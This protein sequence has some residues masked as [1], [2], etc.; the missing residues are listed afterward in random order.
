M[1]IEEI[2]PE[3]LEQLAPDQISE[4][5]EPT[6]E[7]KQKNRLSIIEK[8]RNFQE[9][10]ESLDEP[11]QDE[12]EALLADIRAHGHYVFEWIE[13]LER[14]ASE[15][16]EKAR[17]FADSAKTQEN[18]AK[19]AKDYLKTAMKV[20]G[21]EKFPMGDFTLQLIKSMDYTAKTTASEKDFLANYEY[22]EPTFK[23]KHEP[24]VSD[25]VDHQEKIDRIFQWKIDSIKAQIKA[26]QKILDLK[27]TTPEQK[28]SSQIELEKL[29]DLV[30]AEEKFMLKT[31]VNKVEK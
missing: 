7:P 10:A 17:K 12:I 27:K 23:W 16:R 29:L 24:T 3:I 4:T 6:Q 30:R 21:F 2:T 15:L 26:H 20:G 9:L 19:A 18:K 11:D 1:S 22:V 5:S 8:L 14:N 31:V 28:T 13:I 25:W